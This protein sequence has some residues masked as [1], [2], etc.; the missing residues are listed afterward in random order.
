MKKL[1][2]IVCAIVLAVV[3]L[4]VVGYFLIDL[5][6]PKVGLSLAGADSRYHT[7]LQTAL[8]KA[9]FTVLTDTGEDE[10]GRIEALVKKG[11]DL[12]IVQAADPA[13]AEMITEKAGEIPVLFIDR[14]PE[15]PDAGYFVGY[16]PVQRGQMQAALLESYF[17]KADAN[18][19]K[20]V[21]YMLLSGEDKD[22]YFQGADA[23]AEAYKT[24]KLEEAVCADTEE[25]AMA[26][27][28]QAFSRYGRDLE[29]ILCSSSRLAQGAVE[30]IRESGRTPGRDVI[31]FG[32]GTVQQCEAYVRT[33]AITAAVVEDEEAFF[34]EV[35]RVT[36]ALLGG[37]NA[38]RENY[39]N[40]KLLTHENVNS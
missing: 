40:Y 28:K 19:D 23:A 27:C 20:A 3:I 36:R 7:I 6:T 14:K 22:G 31:V 25:G 38:A 1:H 18:G 16:D 29:L 11:A 2:R 17:V 10:G 15:N 13:Q 21:A 39:V 33:G 32:A 9:G 12:L 37:R 8:E 24:I 34:D 35:I 30:A 5:V 26:A 4:G